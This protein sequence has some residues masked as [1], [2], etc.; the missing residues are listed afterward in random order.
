MN[1]EPS[2]IDFDRL[3]DSF[4]A[5]MRRGER[6]SL[7]EYVER[8]PQFADE[9][10][11]LFPALA[12]MEGLKP[13]PNNATGSFVAR[14]SSGDGAAIPEQMG[15]YR[16]LRLIGEGGMGVV[17]EA[18][19]E[20]LSAHVALKVLHHRFRAEGKFLQRFRNEARSAARLH[21]TNIVP[22]FDFGDHEGILYYVMQYIPGQGLDRVL[23]DL[24]R[25][26]EAGPSGLRAPLG[27]SDQ[28][29]RSVAEGLMTGRFRGRPEGDEELVEPGSTEAGSGTAVAARP[30]LSDPHDGGASSLGAATGP[31]QGRFHREIARIGAQVAD[32]LAH[33]HALGVLHRDI[34][35]S[36][37][38]LDARGDVWVADFGLAKFEESEDLTDPGDMLGTLRYMAPERLDGKSDRRGDI[39]ALGATLYEMI[40]LRPAFDAPDR[41]RLVRQILDDEPP[42]LRK[43]DRR[44]PRDLETILHKAMARDA[45]ARY[46]TAGAMAD[47]LRLF[48]QDRPIG[49]RRSTPAEKT[50]LWC[51]RNPIVASLL[52]LIG[53]ILVGGT[54]AA[55]I[56]AYRFR[57]IASSESLA[58]A[59]SD[60]LARSET[61]A[62]ADSDRLAV[63]EA[64]ARKEAGRR[65]AEA[66]AVVDFFVKDMLAT[67]RPENPLGRAA[68]VDDMLAQADKSISGRFPDQPLIEA[69]IRHALAETY[70]ATGQD[71]KG[72]PHA[73]RAR[74]LRER[75]LGQDSPESLRSASLL[76]ELLLH[77]P[78]R[79]FEFRLVAEAV[80]RT[81]L[82]T[83]GPDHPDTAEAMAWVG[84]SLDNLPSRLVESQALFDRAIL[85]LRR[86]YGPA[87][88]RTLAAMQGLAW[89][90]R[91]QG[92]L[93]ESVAVYDEILNLEHRAFGPKYLG[94]A[95]ILDNKAETLKDFG[96]LEQ[97]G[98]VYDE[99][100]RIACTV[101]D[102]S[103]GWAQAVIGRSLA[104]RLQQAKA[105]G[106]RAG[107]AA[108]RVILEKAL[109]VFN[110][111][112][113][114]AEAYLAREPNEGQAKLVL[115][116]RLWE[117][118]VV[119]SDL[120]RHEDALKD[121]ERCVSL[122]E[123][124]HNKDHIGEVRVN[125]SWTLA[126]LKRPD[127]AVEALTPV[128]AEHIPPAAL[129][130]VGR[131]Y[132]LA[133]VASSGDPDRARRYGDQAVRMLRWAVAAGFRDVEAL[134]LHP[135]LASLRGREDFRALLTDAAL[136]VDPFRKAHDGLEM[137]LWIQ[138]KDQW[139]TD[140]SI[141]SLAQ[142][143]AENDRLSKEGYR[144]T[145]I[146]ST[147]G[148]FVAPT[149][150]ATWTADKKPFLVEV[151]A[152]RDRFRERARTLPA[153][154]RPA[155][156]SVDESGA[157]P[158]WT[159]IWVKDEV[160]V[161]WVQRDD[162]SPAE[163]LSENDRLKGTGYRPSILV[164]HRDPRGATRYTGVWVKDGVA[165]RIFLR[166]SAD[167]VRGLHDALPV[168][169]NPCWIDS[170]REGRQRLYTVIAIEN[171]ERPEWSLT[172]E[173]PAEV[174]APRTGPSPTPWRD[175]PLLRCVD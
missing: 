174:E 145:C 121:I 21:H 6:P 171:P 141:W 155:W 123:S 151:Y 162:L 90:Y 32:A 95:G 94:L 135:D 143:R 25:L 63:A 1:G 106:Q 132:A 170:A 52:L 26:R 149:F 61:K 165:A 144:P 159:E 117:R 138:L 44:V 124:I 134:R 172:I 3:A 92:K 161:P 164:S 89:A 157:S 91:T 66:R 98:E 88:R 104:L 118:F 150:A 158:R 163:V 120:G 152:E 133:A 115:F 73:A 87:D 53:L 175:A 112:V 99:A 4:V 82:R 60:R 122:S 18:R 8:Y 166:V 55:S 11:D 12:E 15:D 14:P 58:R 139:R 69:S 84:H 62:R 65:E 74:E 33:A 19:R 75:F 130:H 37:L 13:D 128:K 5:R 22:V 77:M 102:P 119:L 31:G 46:Q 108:A 9:V 50:W 156:I 169:W 27:G 114:R 38:L 125:L 126:R 93:A 103:F 109:P 10:L 79:Y 80:L 45:A 153:G 76:G 111:G 39:Y 24:R 2:G 97:A 23:I 137:T 78:F 29:T 68:T 107:P 160:A 48:L 17:Y 28:L 70:L 131:I 142:L 72:E 35:P 42:L 168:T 173:T 51:R 127:D 85:I 47:D 49:A 30:P 59:E 110:L 146:T 7:S 34:K 81:R 101:P 154:Y 43:L 36:N 56:A 16:I 100:V 116:G 86:A 71:W 167:E 67:A 136:P 83:L 54:T 64:G 129:A 140:R 113:T 147:P 40:A 96:K 41:G 105:E 57:R 20:S 148:A